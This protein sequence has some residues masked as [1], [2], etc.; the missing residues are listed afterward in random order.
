[1]LLLRCPL[2]TQILVYFNEYVHLVSITYLQSI[3]EFHQ[4]DS[5]N[6]FTSQY[7]VACAC[8][9]SFWHSYGYG[10]SW[11]HAAES[12]DLVK[13]CTG[14]S[15]VDR[16]IYAVHSIYKCPLTLDQ[17]FKANVDTNIDSEKSIC[18][19]SRRQLPLSGNLIPK[20]GTT[21][22]MLKLVQFFKM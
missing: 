9:Q 4:P 11:H 8:M 20:R 18:L 5:A 12:V 1:M 13:I 21:T 19:C 14:Q 6:Y 15:K 7:Y 22:S 16:Q 3:S 17:H 10:L 2:Q